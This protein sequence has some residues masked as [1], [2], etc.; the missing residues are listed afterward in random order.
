M[1]YQKKT[2]DERKAII[3]NAFKTIEEKVPQVFTSDGYKEYLNTMS[4]F[5]NYSINNQILIATQKPEATLVAGFNAWKDLER[6]VNKG[7]KGIMI[8]APAPYKYHK[9]VDK[10]DEHGN[11]VKNDKGETEKEYKEYQAMSYKPVYVFDISQT[12]GKEL[13]LNF[14]KALDGNSKEARDLLEAVESVSDFSINYVS[15]EDDLTLARGAKGYFSHLTEEITIN[16]DLSLDQKAKTLIHEFAHGILHN[17]DN[18]KSKEQKEIEAES[19][20]Y[21]VSNY[22]GLD[23]SD[24]SFNYVASWAA[25]KETEELKGILT[26]IQKATDDII[27]KVEDAYIA[28]KEK[29]KDLELPVEEVAE[30]EKIEE[31]KETSEPEQTEEITAPESEKVEEPT[32]EVP[33]TVKEPDPVSTEVPEDD[34]SDTDD[35]KEETQEEQPEEKEPVEEPVNTTPVETVPDSSA[36]DK[37]EEKKP[38]QSIQDFGEKIGGARKDIWGSRGLLIDDLSFMN[39]AE[40]SKLIKKDNVW[41]KPDYQKLVDEGLPVEVAYFYKVARNACPTKPDIKRYCISAEDIKEEQEKYVAFVSDLKQAVFNCKTIDDIKKMGNWLEENEYV[42]KSGYYSLTPTAKADGLIDNKLYKGLKAGEDISELRKNIKKEE[43]CFTEE[44][45]MLSYYKIIPYIK[46]YTSFEKDYMDRDVISIG[47]SSKF[48]LYPKDPEYAK[49]ENYKDGTFF[50]L[51]LIGKFMGKNFETQEAAEKFCLEHYKELHKDA[52]EQTEE[53]KSTR[54]TAL[55]PPMLSGIKRLGGEDYRENKDVSGQDYLDT[56]NFKGGE[57]G[58][59]LNDKERQESLNFGYDAFKDFAKALN[60]S[61]TD[62]T[63]N[64]KLNIAFGARGKGNALAH[65]EPDRTVINLTKMKGAGS[66]GHELIHFLDDNIGKQL[67]LNGFMSENIHKKE[68]PESFKELMQTM[69]Y[70]TLSPTEAQ[71]HN[72]EKLN[73]KLDF[74]RSE[75]SRC[76]KKGDTPEKEAKRQ[77]LIEAVVQEARNTHGY[78]YQTAYFTGRTMKFK[79]DKNMSPAYAALH[80]YQVKEMGDNNLRRNI[81]WC[82]NQRSLISTLAEQVD[83]PTPETLTR[84]DSTKFY[85]DAEIIDEN[86]S[87]SKKGYWASEIEM[88]ARAGAAYIKDKLA[89]QGIRNDYLCGHA[90]QPG[91]ETPNGLVYTS[92]QGEERKAINQAFDKFFE[93]IKEL[94]IFH[95]PEQELSSL[96]DKLSAAEEKAASQTYNQKDEIAKDEIAI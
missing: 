66:L 40:R 78:E 33:E 32:V 74:F 77:E 27:N 71:K 58:N 57:F 50:V 91:I 73:E 63:L 59:W 82:N 67:G 20:A 44:Q 30:P 88:L 89:E 55:K 83:N 11:A 12:S 21:A 3:D 69:K 36:S 8:L 72:E 38:E 48:F 52:P 28:I 31:E 24:Y 23:T 95:E 15:K 43:F 16:K 84:R 7:E 26:N 61:D 53:K 92:P 46:D 9:E 76:S 42:V 49:P 2:N 51:D 17:D 93:E 4:K 64:G 80:E 18:S 22:F 85:K 62:V 41:P 54:K 79:E 60:I 35:I 65:Y 81:A 5:H 14:V 56:F 29:N 19:V 1:A 34:S 96:E 39:E 45:K 13:A 25:G 90:D 6:S 47:K 86:Y 87:S 94:G 37:K 68:V 75:L 10:V 70:K